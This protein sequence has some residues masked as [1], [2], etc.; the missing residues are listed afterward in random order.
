MDTVETHTPYGLDAIGR[1]GIPARNRTG[2]SGFAPADSMFACTWIDGRDLLL[3]LWPNCPSVPTGATTTTTSQPTNQPTHRA[4]ASKVQSSSSPSSPNP[5]RAGTA[6][7]IWGCQGKPSEA[8]ISVSC[9]SINLSVLITQ[10]SI[11]TFAIAH[12]HWQSAR[13]L[14]NRTVDTAIRPRSGSGRSQS[15]IRVPRSTT[16]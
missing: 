13:L 4:A 11:L 2:Q 15:L 8:I 16:L 1:G 7:H 3:F 14:R 9:L 12:C 5:P 6:L 10:G